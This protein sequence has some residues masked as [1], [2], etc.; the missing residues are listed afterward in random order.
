M[1]IG[2]ISNNIN[3]PQDDITFTTYMVM[4]A[5]YRTVELNMPVNIPLI[6]AAVGRQ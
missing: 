6:F 3:N 1:R 5:G 4:K 2:Q